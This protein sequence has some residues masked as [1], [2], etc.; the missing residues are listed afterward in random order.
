M[1]SLKPFITLISIFFLCFE[2]NAQDTFPKLF[3]QNH[4]DFLF[5]NVPNDVYIYVPAAT[6]KMSD[7]YQLKVSSPSVIEKKQLTFIQ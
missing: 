2:I 1:N 3:S 5:M 7:K 6:D 4:Y